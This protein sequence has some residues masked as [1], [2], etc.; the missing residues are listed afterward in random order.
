MTEK[1]RRAD[2]MF[3][4]MIREMNDSQ[5]IDLTNNYTNKESIPSWL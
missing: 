4:M 2:L 5:S 3:E 1:A